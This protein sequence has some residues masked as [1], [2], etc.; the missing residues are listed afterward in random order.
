[1]LGSGA[2]VRQAQVG[3]GHNGEAHDFD[4]DSI[5]RLATDPVVHPILETKS[6]DPLDEVKEAEAQRWVKA[7]NAEGSFGRWE[8]RMARN[9]NDAGQILATSSLEAW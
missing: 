8:F 3:K 1:M 4:P 5:V 2:D 9:P 7:V 6:Y